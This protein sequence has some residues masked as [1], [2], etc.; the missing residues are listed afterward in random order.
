MI[1]N[2]SQ[3]NQLNILASSKDTISGVNIPLSMQKSFIY[4]GGVK[5]IDIISYLCYLSYLIC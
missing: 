1:Y 2:K 5:S 4:F 3:I